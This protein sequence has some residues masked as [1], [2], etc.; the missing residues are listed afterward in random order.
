[1]GWRGEL[2]MKRYCRALFGGLLTLLLC[3]GGGAA[4]AQDAALKPISAAECQKYAAQAQGVTGFAMKASEE[5][6]TDVSDGSDGRSCHIAGS[7][8]GQSF[9]VPSELMG[10]IA[11]VFGEWKDEPARDAAGADGAEKGFV[12]GSRIATV[13]VSWEPGPGVSCSEKQPL[14]ACK[15]Q[16]QQKLWTAIVDIV[17]KAGK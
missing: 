1:M 12:S 6:F 5:D 16:P 13:Q 3:A 15:I 11:A 17:E 7:A 14:S 4:W 8:S 2:A 10:K 9:T